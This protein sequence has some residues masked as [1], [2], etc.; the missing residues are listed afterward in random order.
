MLG[1]SE[2]T[3]LHPT[4]LATDRPNMPS[5]DRSLRIGMAAPTAGALALLLLFC[6]FGCDESS[7]T[8][9]KQVA[10]LEAVQIDG[11]SESERSLLES[12]SIASLTP[13]PA[14]PSNRVAGDPVAAELGHRLF[15][16]PGLSRDGSLSCAS[17]HVADL[18]FTDGRPTSKGLAVTGRNAPTLVGSAHSTW[19]FWDGRRDSLW[20]QALGPL[21]TAAEMGSTR[22]AVVRHVVGDPQLAAL[23]Q[24]VFGEVPAIGDADRFPERAGPFGD[25]VERDAWHRMTAADKKMVDTAFANVGKAIEAYERLLLP[26]PSRFDDYVE[27]LRSRGPDSAVATLNEEEIVGLRLFVDAG[28]TLCLRC[29]NGPLLTNQAFHDIGTASGEGRLPDFGRFLGLQAVL[30]DPFNCL[31]PYSDA[32][33]EDCKELRFIDKR[34]AD[35]EMGKFKTPTLRGLTRTGPYMHDGRFVTLEEVVDFYRSPPVGPEPLEITPLE[36]DDDEAKA[37]SAF[38]RTLDGGIAVDEHW[39]RAPGAANVAGLRAISAP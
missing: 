13:P 16:D 14:N 30:I 3:S 28:R 7:P 9:E 20:A 1:G 19:Q 23:Y 31:G 36:I 39:L 25:G 5:V 8:T 10:P 2:D 32:P 17:C 11:W 26:G 38:L 15:F 29:H 34:H 27:R 21:E 6:A 24:R 35:L 33:Q 22:L 12:L 4:G 37:L 18:L